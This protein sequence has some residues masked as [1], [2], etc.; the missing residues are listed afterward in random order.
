MGRLIASSVTRNLCGLDMTGNTTSN[1]TVS[2]FGPDRGAAM[3]RN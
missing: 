3:V 1:G 2:E